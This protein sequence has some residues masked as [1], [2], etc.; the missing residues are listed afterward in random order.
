MLDV[1]LEHKA[2][3][4]IRDDL[5]NYP[6]HY[7]IDSRSRSCVDRMLS[8]SDQSLFSGELHPLWRC[9]DRQA[10]EAAILVYRRGWSLSEAD[11]NRIFDLAASR[12][13]ASEWNFVVEKV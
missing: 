1:L 7:A 12:G 5:G 8:A 9:I 4:G 11:I 2:D 6:L 10:W 13:L 3:A